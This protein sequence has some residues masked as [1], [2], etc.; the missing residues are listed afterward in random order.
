MSLINTVTSSS[1]V[2]SE[3]RK[4]VMTQTFKDLEV[5]AMSTFFSAEQ[6]VTS[7]EFLCRVD[8]G[9]GFPDDLKTIFIESV[10]GFTSP[11]AYR[12]YNW[13]TDEKFN[14]GTRCRVNVNRHLSLGSLPRAS[15]CSKSLELPHYKDV[16]TMTQKLSLATHSSDYGHA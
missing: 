2:S 6:A 1:K 8:Y 4:A 14:R 10:T 16:E 12:L 11:E 3:N 9:D 7:E 15:T 5:E 13:I